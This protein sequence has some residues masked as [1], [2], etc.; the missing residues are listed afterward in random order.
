[1]F[2][3]EKMVA[4]R[5]VPLFGSLGPVALEE[6]AQSSTDT[7]YASGEALCIEGEPGDE[8]FVMLD[9]NATVV[10]G[11]TPGGAVLRVE[12]AGSVIG[13]MAV[14]EATL[15]SASVFAGGAGA[16]VLRLHGAAFHA[17]LDADPAVAEGVIRTL[18]RRIRTREVA[19][20]NSVG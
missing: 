4:L 20:P 8:V 15:R 14:L 7:R 9:G 2:T 11:A 18:A 12:T 13:E 10:E 6:L 3:V 16:R 17:V 5:C 19:E 1:M